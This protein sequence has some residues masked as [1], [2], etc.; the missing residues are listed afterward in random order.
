MA[1]VIRFPSHNQLPPNRVEFAK[2][3]RCTGMNALI[4]GQNAII[5]A[6]AMLGDRVPSG[7]LSTR[8]FIR[9]DLLAVG[10][11]NSFASCLRWRFR[12]QRGCAEL[13]A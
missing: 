12:G 6:S 13:I 3:I 7:V 11:L 1:F 9:A 4:A 2:P 5:T 10:W 8:S